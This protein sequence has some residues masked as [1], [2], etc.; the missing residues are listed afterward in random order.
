[1]KSPPLN[2]LYN[3]MLRNLTFTV[4]ALLLATLVDARRRKEAPKISFG[5]VLDAFGML[6]KPETL[7][8]LADPTP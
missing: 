3:N 4:L 5:E 6:P 2:L 7:A 1:M 8:K